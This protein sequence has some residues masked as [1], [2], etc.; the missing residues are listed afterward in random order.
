MRTSTLV[1]LLAA[2]F[3]VLA[4]NNT[5]VETITSVSTFLGVNS[6]HEATSIV[7]TIVQTI[8]PGAQPTGT[9]NSS[10]N[11]TS[12][13]G[14]ASAGGNST[15]GTTAQTTSTGTP[16]SLLPTAATSVDGGGTQAGGAPSPGATVNGQPLGPPDSF[17]AKAMSLQIDILVPS[18]LALA[19]G[20][21]MVLA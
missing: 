4:Q 9:T 6:A 3:V 12:V 17:V 7:T 13:N 14:T 16:L 1:A 15:N 2:P 11:G 21:W 8:T 18:V 20:F 19:G 5:G 10:T